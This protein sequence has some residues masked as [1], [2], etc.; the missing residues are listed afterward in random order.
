[1]NLRAKFR[2]TASKVRRLEGFY[3]ERVKSGS[4][5]PMDYHYLS[6]YSGVRGGT[7]LVWC[8]LDGGTEEEYDDAEKEM[9]QQSGEVVN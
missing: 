4:D 1:M 7:N 9:L 3:L 2:N 6:Y 8:G 5:D